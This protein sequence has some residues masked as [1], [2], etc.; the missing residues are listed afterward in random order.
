MV[1]IGA[2]VAVVAGTVHNREVDAPLLNVTY[3]LGT[4]VAIS[5]FGGW[6][7]YTFRFLA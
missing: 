6:T 7:S 2:S 4:I 5:T 3:I 1:S